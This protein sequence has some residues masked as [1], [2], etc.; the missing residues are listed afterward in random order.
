MEAGIDNQYEVAIFWDYENV[1]IPAR[2]TSPLK[3]CSEIVKSAATFGRIQQRRVYSDYSRD[4]SN[5]KQWSADIG[6]SGFDL[7]STPRRGAM[8]KET[9]DRKMINDIIFFAWDVLFRK[10]KPCVVLITSDGD[11]AYTINKLRD[12]GCANVVI[13]GTNVS[14]LLVNSADT[15]L[16]LE[17]D[18]LSKSILP[19]VD[20]PPPGFVD[21][22]CVRLAKLS[23][24][25]DSRE[26]S[27]AIADSSSGATRDD[28]DKATTGIAEKE[29]PSMVPIQT[30]AN[31]KLD[32]ILLCKLLVKCFPQWEYGSNIGTDFKASASLLEPTRAD[33][34]TRFRLA[35]A[36]A[37]D[38][39]WILRGRQRVKPD[40]SFGEVV[41]TCS[42]AEVNG[43]P[44]GELSKHQFLKVSDSGLRQLI[45]ISEQTSSS[46]Q[47]SGKTEVAG[48][49]RQD[50]KPIVHSTPSSSV[51]SSC[52][53][54][55]SRSSKT[56]EWKQ[57]LRDTK[58]RL[59]TLSKEAETNVTACIFVKN[60]PSNVNVRD[61]VMF[62]ENETKCTVLRATGKKTVPFSPFYFV[63]LSVESSEQATLILRLATDRQ[64]VLLGRVL[65][66]DFD[67]WP[68]TSSTGIESSMLY[69]KGD[70]TNV[71][72]SLA[73]LSIYFT[74]IPNGTNIQDFVGDIEDRF[75]VSIVQAKIAD[76]NDDYD[77][78]WNAHARMKSRL[79]FLKLLSLTEKFGATK[80]M[81]EGRAI[82]IK[83][84]TRIP[85][86]ASFTQTN[87]GTYF[88][89]K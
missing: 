20:G 38:S 70:K 1:P 3:A 66:A 56:G 62:L 12:R 31:V 58:P 39:G 64:L 79:D 67:R 45:P 17:K 47:S 28:T 43:Q 14:A 59:S 61:F 78:F 2:C 22:D 50:C 42:S 33:F 27:T 85:N 48:D 72:V 60:I 86:W 30:A 83:Q 82:G 4:D 87:S 21:K 40:G 52:S 9:L 36:H 18:I 80:L 11:F 84:D 29:Q 37:V 54:G 89:R 51:S 7:V 5:M 10:G 35:V 24:S 19:A 8:A 44:I 13:H 71:A 81:Y 77:Y 49:L 53:S 69:R 34:K 55:S 15:A 26:A 76:R 68:A 73:D 32:A 46:T 23:E 16:G 41:H 65:S 63:R 25:K 6:E 88:L 57:V 75:S 74:N